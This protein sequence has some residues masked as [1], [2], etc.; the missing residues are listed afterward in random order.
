M[1]DMTHK[2]VP[3]EPTPAMRLAGRKAP[4]MVDDLWAAMLKA[5]PPSPVTELEVMLADACATMAEWDDREKD[6]S[7]D[8]YARM[9]LCN[10]AFEKARAALAAYE[11]KKGK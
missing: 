3:V 6:H 2:T 1:S 4:D 9:E 11:A 7:I 10:L 5:A 8:F